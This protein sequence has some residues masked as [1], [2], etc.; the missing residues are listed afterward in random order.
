MV[1]DHGHE[2][3]HDVANVNSLVVVALGDVQLRRG[4]DLLPAQASVDAERDSNYAESHQIGQER[5]HEERENAEPQ[6][7]K[8]ENDESFLLK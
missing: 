7:V 4:D 3:S 8:A 5:G 6:Q 2:G 1:L